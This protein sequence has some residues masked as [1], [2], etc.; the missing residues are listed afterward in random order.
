MRLPCGML[1]QIIEY[2]SFAA[3]YWGYQRQ[4]HPKEES[5][6]LRLVKLIET[7]RA[8]K[9]MGITFIP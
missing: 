8:A 6:M 2:R 5:E 7:E 4:Q 9:R 1:E 3:T